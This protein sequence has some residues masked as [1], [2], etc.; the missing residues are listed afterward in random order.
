MKTTYPR[1]T[2]LVLLAAILGGSPQAPGQEAK[3]AAPAHVMVTP[4]DLQWAEGPGSVPPGAK[5]AVI[6]GD[7]KNAALFTMRL[8]LP[9]NYR[10]PAHWHPADEHVT[11]LSGTFHMGMG[12]KLDTT[13]GKGLVVGSFAVMPA[14]TQ[15]FAWTNEGTIIQ[16]HGMGPWGITYVNPADDPRKK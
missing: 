1:R 9:A 5:F 6:E 4:T 16:L 13:K 3:P 7:P 2:V 15:H 14:N 11:V 8:K 12:E 10:I